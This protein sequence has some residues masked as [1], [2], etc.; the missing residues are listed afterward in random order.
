[1]EEKI[2]KKMVKESQ[3]DQRIK[4]IIMI[5]IKHEKQNK[6]R[7]FIKFV[8][9]KNKLLSSQYTFSCLILI[10]SLFQ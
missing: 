6:I 2:L 4:K 1:M 8:I 9:K 7:F 10:L 5:K 3:G